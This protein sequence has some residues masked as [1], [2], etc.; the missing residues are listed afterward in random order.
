MNP[1][2]PETHLRRLFQEQRSADALR[3]PDY[4]VLAVAR[5]PRMRLRIRWGSLTAAATMTAMIL[6]VLL[7]V[8]NGRLRQPADDMTDWAKFSQWKASTD[9]LLS[10]PR[11]AWETQS[12]TLS[13]SS[14][15]AK[16]KG[17]EI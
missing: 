17:S 11:A 7:T 3:A 16:D 2:N 12:Q 9:A 10:V 5:S 13:D 15:P 1:D 14:L 8:I 4:H 6:V